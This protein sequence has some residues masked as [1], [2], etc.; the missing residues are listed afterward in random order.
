MPRRRAPAILVAALAAVTGATAAHAGAS[1]PCAV[2]RARVSAAASQRGYQA[3]SGPSGLVDA[4]GTQLQ[5]RCAAGSA[6]IELRAR[7]GARVDVALTADVASPVWEL[8]LRGEFAGVGWVSHRAVVH[9]VSGGEVRGFLQYAAEAGAELAF[10]EV[11]D[12]AGGDPVSGGDPQKISEALAPV[13]SAAKIWHDGY[14]LA[15]ALAGLWDGVHAESRGAAESVLEA[16]LD[17]AVPAPDVG[18]RDK[19]GKKISYACGGALVSCGAA[20]LLK[21]AFGSGG[22]CGGGGSACL[23]AIG[24]TWAD[25]EGDDAGFDTTTG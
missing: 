23:T 22:A 6:A 1:E 20:L 19:D 24:C 21:G 2:L 9:A 17:L 14:L 8:E 10:V 15:F 11:D 3:A 12:F 4:A 18:P 13:L 5:L 7:D 16:M 25:C